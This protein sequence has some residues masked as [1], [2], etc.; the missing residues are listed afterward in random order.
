MRLQFTDKAKQ[1]VEIALLKGSDADFVGGIHQVTMQASGVGYKALERVAL[2]A[3]VAFV[4]E[5]VLLAPPPRGLFDD[6]FF[7]ILHHRRGLFMV[8]ARII[9]VHGVGCSWPVELWAISSHF[10]FDDLRSMTP[11]LARP[12]P[13]SDHSSCNL[14]RGPAQQESFNNDL[15][16]TNFKFKFSK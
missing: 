5:Q 10:L 16:V 4:V 8:V 7:G 12:N 3:D 1:L 11:K 13:N 15:C 9:Q 6:F 2:R 14:Y